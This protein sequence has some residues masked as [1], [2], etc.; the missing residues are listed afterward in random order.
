MSEVG[1]T[2]IES[3]EERLAVRSICQQ[4]QLL[5][6]DLLE[7]WRTAIQFGHHARADELSRAGHSLR[8]AHQALT[9][10]LIGQQGR[11]GEHTLD[12]GAEPD[13]C[14]Y[15]LGAMNTSSGPSGD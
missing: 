4:L 5:E 1:L 7:L 11:W 9:T 3:R 14:P 6:V 13:R 8:S 15:A 12:C 2:G 10:D